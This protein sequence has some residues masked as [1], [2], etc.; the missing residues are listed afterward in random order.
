MAKVLFVVGLLA[1]WAALLSE[2]AFI[3][4]RLTAVN[5]E[6]TTASPSSTY[7]L[8]VWGSIGAGALCWAVAAAILVSGRLRDTK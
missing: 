6:T 5:G 7:G 3:M 2:I 4:L 1:F 8:V